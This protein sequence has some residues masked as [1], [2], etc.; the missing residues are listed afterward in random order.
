MESAIRR[1]NMTLDWS[2]CPDPKLKGS[3]FR[4][5]KDI[6]LAL[7]KFE[8]SK[9]PPNSAA[10]FVAYYFGAEKLAKAIAGIKKR[11]PAEVAFLPARRIDPREI[12]S[13]AR[14]MNLS[15]PTTELNAL[16]VGQETLQRPSTAREIR[17]RL[18]HDFGPTNVSHIHQH[19]PRLIPIM[20]RFI[21]DI[22][23][24]LVHLQ[25]LWK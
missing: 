22:D 7:D 4:R 3:Y 21:D 15:I 2:F 11:D 12:R 5:I 23:R 19:A 9:L 17:N 8:V 10:Q 13:A 20:V 24:V 6:P 16:F 1:F 18:S 25:R 14:A